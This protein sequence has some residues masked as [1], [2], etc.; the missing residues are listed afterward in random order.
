MS[1]NVDNKETVRYFLESLP[2]EKMEQLKDALDRNEALTSTRTL[3]HGDFTVYREGFYVELKGTRCGFKFF[4]DEDDEGNLV[5]TRKPNES[6]LHKEYK[7][8]LHF[9]AV[10]YKGF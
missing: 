3:E 7:E 9:S 2:T 5:F 1:Y 8:S 4:V 10:D 6:K